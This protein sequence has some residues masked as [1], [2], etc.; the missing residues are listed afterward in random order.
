MA[1]KRGRRSNSNGARG[2]QQQQQQQ[3]GRVGLVAVGNES[4]MG[5]PLR[6]F[7][8]TSEDEQLSKQQ[9]K[10]KLRRR[11]KRG[12]ARGAMNEDFGDNFNSELFLDPELFRRTSKPR[13]GF[14]VANGHL[15]SDDNV[16]ILLRQAELRVKAKRKVATGPGSVK[17]R[18]SRKELL[19]A[20]N[21]ERDI[22]NKTSRKRS[23]GKNVVPGRSNGPRSGSSQA[24]IPQNRLVLSTSTRAE[25]QLLAI[26]NLTIGIDRENLKEVLQKVGKCK[27]ASIKL[28]DLPTGSATAHV[29]MAR[30][31]VPELERL[32]VMFNGAQV[33]GRVIQVNITS[34][35]Q[36]GRGR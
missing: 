4:D 8:T 35:Q 28:R 25:D 2:T 16:G 24:Q 36:L 13:R 34:K 22:A 30:P 33:D 12:D 32:Q 26:S 5:G 17:N 21:A 27:I 9:S 6:I 11:R 18:A 15:L 3:N 20:I 19:E 29:M 10:N 7:T 23:R 1:G 31:S 14:S